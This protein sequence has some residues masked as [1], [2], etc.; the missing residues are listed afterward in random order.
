[1]FNEVLGSRFICR[2]RRGGKQTLAALKRKAER[3]TEK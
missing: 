3:F 2:G 1:M